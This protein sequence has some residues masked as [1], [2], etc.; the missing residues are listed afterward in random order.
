MDRQRYN[1]LRHKESI[2]L[3]DAATTDAQQRTASL[4]NKMV[5]LLHA[6]LLCLVALVM[7]FILKGQYSNLNQFLNTCTYG[8][9][10]VDDER[11]LYV[12]VKQMGMVSI[13]YIL[14]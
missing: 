2:H 10:T 8:N 11:E 6:L 14:R 4:K 13:L 3:S 12:P 5:H 1:L 9:H 7:F